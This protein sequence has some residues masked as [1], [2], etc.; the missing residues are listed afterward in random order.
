MNAL[1]L[2]FKTPKLSFKQRTL[3][4]P[5]PR[6]KPLLN[7]DDDEPIRAKI[8]GEEI[9]LEKGSASGSSITHK[10]YVQL[11]YMKEKPG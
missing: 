7:F 3:R 2:Y 6:R 10:G 9:W 1:Y 4:I 8:F 11:R 5:L